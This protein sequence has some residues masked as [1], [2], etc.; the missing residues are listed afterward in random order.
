[1]FEH[2]FLDKMGDA[3]IDAKTYWHDSPMRKTPENERFVS[4]FR[5]RTKR[6]PGAFAAQAYTA[7]RAIDQALKAHGGN[8]EDVDQFWTLESMKK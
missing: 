5:G 3:A 2:T 6:L 7:M 1:M 8:V 4:L